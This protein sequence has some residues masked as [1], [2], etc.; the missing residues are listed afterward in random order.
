METTVSS[1]SSA[2]PRDTAA[3]LI[4]LSRYVHLI[5]LYEII[6]RFCRKFREKPE[7]VRKCQQ[8]PTSSFMS[9]LLSHTRAQE[10]LLGL[11][12][13]LSVLCKEPDHDGI[14]K[15]FGTMANPG[16]PDHY[17]VACTVEGYPEAATGLY[18]YKNGNNG[19]EARDTAGAQTFD[20]DELTFGVF[21][22]KTLL[23]EEL[24][25]ECDR[26]LCND[27]SEAEDE[28]E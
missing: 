28:D 2:V 3:A 7:S 13:K 25:D 11:L 18:T 15:T 24:G 16:P 12:A 1:D 9:K 21:A 8:A 27:N 5:H 4:I 19:T 10:N 26:S 14:A 20:A 6:F 22:L 17:F 23:P